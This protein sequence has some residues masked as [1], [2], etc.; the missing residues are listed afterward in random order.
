M[1]STNKKTPRL[2]DLK[3]FGPKSEEILAR[4]DIHSVE[5]FLNCDGFELYAA[6]KKTVKGTGLNSIYAILGA[7]QDVHW[8]EVARTQKYEILLRLDDMG[9]APAKASKKQASKNKTAEE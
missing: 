1:A 9:L 7:Q 5:Q 3:G 4:V 6:L 8:Q 2:R